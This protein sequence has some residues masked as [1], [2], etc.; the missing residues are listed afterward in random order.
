MTPSSL[1]TAMGI[2][3]EA[4]R[5]EMNADHASQVEAAIAEYEAIRRDAL[6][7][8]WLRDEQNER[9]FQPQVTQYKKSNCNVSDRVALYGEQLDVALDSAMS[10]EVKR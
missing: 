3:L 1:A 7:Y 10:H 8:R 2:P 9:A 5:D 6:R 4:L